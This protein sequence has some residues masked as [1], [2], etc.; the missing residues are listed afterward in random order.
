MLLNKYNYTDS[1]EDNEK[2][3]RLDYNVKEKIELN[4]IKINYEKID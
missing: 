1:K 2:D 4:K 3:Y